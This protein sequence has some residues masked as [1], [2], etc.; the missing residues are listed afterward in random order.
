MDYN[1]LKVN[2]LKA[3]L[4]ARNLDTKGVKAV[5]VERLKEAIEKE[6]SEASGDSSAAAL[7]NL[8][9]GTPGQS[10]RRSRRRSMTRSPSPSKNETLKSKSTKEKTEQVESVDLLSSRKKRRTRSITK[11]PSPD[12]SNQVDRLEVLEEEQFVDDDKILDST[13]EKQLETDQGTPKAQETIS[14][15]EDVNP[16]TET[17]VSVEVIPTSDVDAIPETDS[18]K[19][20]S[21]GADKDRQIES[22]NQKVNIDDQATSDKPSEEISKSE[23]PTNNPSSSTA[24]IKLA[25]ACIEFLNEE[26]E[27]E[28]DNNKVLL[29][30]FDSDLNLEIDAV[31]FDEAK[32]FSEGALSLLWAAARANFGTTKGKIKFE[33]LLTHTNAFR[34]V[35]EEPVTSE[36]RVGWSVVDGNL[37]LGESKHSYAYASTGLK[38]TNSIFSDYAMEYKTNDVIG[39]YLNLDS[40]P[41]TIGYTV[42]NVYQG[43]AFEFEKAELDGKAL[44]PHICCKNI[45]FKVNFGELQHSLLND[46]PEKIKTSQ[47]FDKLPEAAVNK[48]CQHGMQEP[49]KLPVDQIDQKE[50]NKKEKLEPDAYPDSDYMYIAQSPSLVPGPCGPKSRNECEVIMLIGL[51]ASGK[52]HWV[53]NYLKENAEKKITVLGVESMLN[54]MKILGK[55]VT[56]ENTKKWSRLIEQLSKSLNKLIEIAAKRRRNFILDQTNVFPSEQKRKLRGFGGFASRRAVIV[57]PDEKE[58]EQRIKQKTDVFGVEVTEHHLNVMKAHFHIPSK[59]LNWFTSITFAELDE[60]KTIEKVKEHNE[61]GKKALPRGFNRNQSQRRGVTNNQ[62]WNRNFKRYGGFQQHSDYNLQ[63]QRFNSTQ[64]YSQSRNNRQSGGY[65]RGDSVGYTAGRYGNNSDWNRGRY[66]NRVNNLGYQNIQAPRSYGGY[67]RGSGWG[68]PSS[69]CWSYGRNQA[70]DTQQWYSWWQSNLKSMLQSPDSFDAN[71]SH[72]ANVQQYWSPYTQPHNYGRNHQKH[73]SSKNK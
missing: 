66:D 36:F 40:S 12:R 16:T 43:T 19:P 9:V 10:V 4:S 67:R 27:P 57:V 28:I 41:C 2:D 26:N 52:T 42:N 14:E 34:K 48:G 7:K 39:V 3:E 17:P 62:R 49:D 11:S 37:Q 47:E 60:E 50:A 69:N 15:K 54:Q 53:N 31:T 30:W 71:I 1:K 13:Q 8:D 33:V 72:S 58:Y 22:M 51:P 61:V 32:P 18:Q 44:Y 20:E 70:N 63:Q 29:S 5:L 38:G 35:T 46:R 23:K 21:E 55:P 45:G 68:Q 65:V 64:Q 6:N 25:Q 56:P 59:E 73:G 24:Q